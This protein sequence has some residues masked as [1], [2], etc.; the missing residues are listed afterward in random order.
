MLKEAGKDLH[1]A[2]VK[3]LF[4]GAQAVPGG[5]FVGTR[6]RAG[7]ARDPADF[8]LPLE[9]P[10]AIVIPAGIEFAFVFIRPFLRHLMGRMHRAGR[11]VKEERL[12]GCLGLM[13]IQPVDGLVGDVGGQVVFGIGGRLDEGG[14][15][16]QAGM[17]LVGL[18]T[19]KS[20][21]MI[22]AIAGWPAVEGTAAGGFMSRRVMPLAE[23]GGGITVAAQHLRQGGGGLGDHAGIAVIFRGDFRHRAIADMMMV[24]TGQQGG[25][26]GR[27]DGGGVEGIVND[28][29]LGDAGQGRR[30]DLATDG[31][32][33]GE[34]GVVQQNDQHIRRTGRQRF[35][36]AGRLGSQSDLRNSRG[37]GQ[38]DGKGFHCLHGIP[39]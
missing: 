29:A 26:G 38:Q 10:L 22:E 17:V 23:G 12:T 25:A 2:G 21:E 20:V 11:P 33:L 24:A 8:F 34:T 28:A 18:A 35:G 39:P 36:L 19:E 30:V 5:H 27:T 31:I 7:I 9:H 13:L 15:I 3:C 32:G 6:R 4:F 37:A 16:D 14:V 1:L